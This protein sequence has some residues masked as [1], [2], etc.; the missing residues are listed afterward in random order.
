[1][2]DWNED[3]NTVNLEEILFKINKEY[4]GRNMD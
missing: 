3:F 1:M 4:F 2:K